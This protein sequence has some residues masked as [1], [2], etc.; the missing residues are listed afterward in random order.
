MSAVE[1][2][3]GLRKGRWFGKHGVACCP[4]HDDRE[5]SLGIRI[6]TDGRILVKCY[7]GCSQEAV[8]DALRALGLW[9]GTAGNVV[10]FPPQKI[11]RN[12]NGEYALGL[13]RQCKPAAGT[14]VEAY[15]RARGLSLPVPDSWRLH[16]KMKHP[17]GG[18]WPAMVAV[19]TDGVTG[20]PIAIHRTFL[21][22]DGSGKAPVEKSKMMLG[23]CHGGAVRLA[24]VKPGDRLGIGEGIETCLTVI[25]E[26]GNP[27][28]AALSTSGLK[29]LDLPEG[30][31]E[32]VL[33][34]DNDPA[35]Q[36]A[37]RVAGDRWVSEGR[38]VKLAVPD[39]TCNDFNEQLLR[40]AR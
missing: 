30:V 28:W 3:R 8:I 9:S 37:A 38:A 1:V 6:G 25:Q 23:P 27:A 17:E 36:E 7:A 4:A 29:A 39:G 24:D 33:L 15:L 19:V 2:T 18:H 14:V 31:R 40:G 11:E 5:P 32:V 12:S 22:P 34:S 10:P 13:W 35:G 20:K 21:K 26:C 16:P